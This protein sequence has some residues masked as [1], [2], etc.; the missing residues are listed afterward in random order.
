MALN[1]SCERSC[2]GIDRRKDSGT[3]KEGAVAEREGVRF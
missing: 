1:L 3:G 2:F